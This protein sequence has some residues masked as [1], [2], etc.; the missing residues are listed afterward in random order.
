MMRKKRQTTEGN[1]E[2][3]TITSERESSILMRKYGRNMHTSFRGRRPL[4]T[5]FFSQGTNSY[6]ALKQ[7]IGKKPNYWA[8]IAAAAK[9]FQ[10][11]RPAEEYFFYMLSVSCFISCFTFFLNNN[12][13]G[14]NNN[15]ILGKVKTAQFRQLT[16]L[17]IDDLSW[18]RLRSSCGLPS[19]PPTPPAP[20][21]WCRSP[22]VTATI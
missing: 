3:H 1:I 12:E 6:S 15:N 7:T 18:R 2:T 5:S 8:L 19:P 14:N 17:A 22:T 4:P 21:P 10:V 13:N 16:E 20:A 9:P 11:S